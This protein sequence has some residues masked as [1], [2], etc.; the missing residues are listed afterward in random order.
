MIT[1]AVLLIWKLIYFRGDDQLTEAE[2]FMID[3]IAPIG[4]EYFDDG[5][6]NMDFAYGSVIYFSAWVLR[7]LDVHII[8]FHKHHTSGLLTSKVLI[9]K[10]FP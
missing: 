8:P 2:K 6:G 5:V 3:E 4:D 10:V 9:K 1:R 7:Y